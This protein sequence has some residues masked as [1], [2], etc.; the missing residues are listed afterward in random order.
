MPQDLELL[1]T[2]LIK[3]QTEYNRHV[4]LLGSLEAFGNFIHMFLNWIVTFIKVACVSQE[5]AVK[6][7]QAAYKVKYRKCLQSMLRRVTIYAQPSDISQQSI[8]RHE[9]FSLLNLT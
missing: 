2:S 6:C 9:R 1:P 3:L 8:D 5:S 4:N 7:R